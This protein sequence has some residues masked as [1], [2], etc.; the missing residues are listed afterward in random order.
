MS[1]L[2]SATNA[3]VITFWTLKNLLKKIYLPYRGR[4]GVYVRMRAYVHVCVYA[5]MR[6]YVY[7]CHVPM[8]N[9]YGSF[10]LV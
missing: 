1:F 3:G 2:K 8:H 9:S 7:A 6:A 4:A 10:R 5:C